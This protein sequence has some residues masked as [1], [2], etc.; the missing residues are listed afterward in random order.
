MLPKLILTVSFIYF[1]SGNVWSQ[2]T[3]TLKNGITLFGLITEVNKGE[4]RFKIDGGAVTIDQ[5]KTYRKSGELVIFPT[6]NPNQ[7]QTKEIQVLKECDIKNVGDVEIENKTNKE[8]SVTIYATN[9]V[10]ERTLTSIFNNSEIA[11]L[12]ITAGSKITAY[13]LNSGVHFF[14]FTFKTGLSNRSEGQIRI[15]KCETEK[16]IIK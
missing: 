7:N 1:I 12:T 3:I 9:N 11:R 6:N 10:P 8:V 2:D 16:I 14:E 15:T 13:D 5:V 4:I